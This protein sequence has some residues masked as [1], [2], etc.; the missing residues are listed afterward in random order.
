MTLWSRTFAVRNDPFVWVAEQAG[1]RALRR[2]VV[3]GARGRTLEI[4]AGT[5][6]NVPFFPPGLDELIL[7]EPDPAMRARLARRAGAA[8]VLD[9]GAERLPLEDASVDTIVS[10]LVLCT[11]DDLPATLAE[12]SRVLAPGGRLLLIEHVRAHSPGLARWQDRLE[13]AWRAF[14]EGCRCNRDTVAQLTAAGFGEL[15]LR[16]ATWRAMPP[17]V[18]PLVAGSAARG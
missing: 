10:T 8:R 2:E 5:G 16:P 13:P 12:L 14:A 3:A 15:D 9:C 11:V 4:G 17:I 6:L 1:M 7:L 18:G